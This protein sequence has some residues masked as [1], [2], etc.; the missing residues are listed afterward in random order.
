MKTIQN[1]V[2]LIALIISI[3]VIIFLSAIIVSIIDNIP[4]KATKSKF[5]SDLAEIQY[6]VKI[7]RA[8]N[9]FLNELFEKTDIN[10][11]FTKVKIK[12]SPIAQFEDGWVVNLELINIHNST[13]GKEFR[14]IEQNSEILFGRDAPDIYVYDGYEIV[15]YVRGYSDNYYIN[16]GLDYITSVNDSDWSFNAN[17]GT[18]FGYNGP[19]VNDLF[20][21]GYIYG[22]RV[23]SIIGNSENMQ[24]IFYNKNISNVIVANGIDSISNYAFANCK[25]IDNIV[26][27]FSVISIGEKAFMGCTD[28]KSAY[29]PSSVVKIYDN[30]FYNCTDLISINIPNSVVEMGKYTFAGCTDLEKVSIS[31]NTKIIDVGAFYDCRALKEIN[32]PEGVESIMDSAFYNCR[33]LYTISLPSSIKNIDNNVFS[34]CTGLKNILINNKNGTISGI[35]PWGAPNAK[36]AWS[37]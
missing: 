6:S 14:N 10:K 12:K 2:A 3:V 17:T 7:K 28:L 22:I 18:I 20:I 37:I 4:E 19:N 11:G 26:L 36:V 5:I 35:A 16:Y 1:G 25:S 31:S 9:L 27:P 30:A 32:I 33:N 15:Y 34:N 13:W 23:I 24:G 21:P 8:Q 29:I